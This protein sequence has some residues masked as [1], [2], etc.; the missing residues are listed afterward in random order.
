MMH[1][2][3]HATVINL[4]EGLSDRVAVA[5]Q[6]K[7]TPLE[8]VRPKDR[9]TTLRFNL[10]F[11]LNYALHLPTGSATGAGRTVNLGSGGALF[12]TPEEIQKDAEIHLSIAWPVTLDDGVPLRLFVVGQVLRSH[13]GYTAVKFLVYQFR[14][15]HRG[16]DVT[17]VSRWYWGRRLRRKPS[18]NGDNG[19]ANVG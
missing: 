17:P 1:N 6:G 14:T 18:D 2:L 5:L 7:Q 12:Q 16:S 13:Q 8:M 10:E 4:E 19:A 15:A 9:R 11:E 3:S